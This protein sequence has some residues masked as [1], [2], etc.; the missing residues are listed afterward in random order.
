MKKQVLLGAAL[1]LFMYST[2]IAE[3]GRSDYDLDNDGLIEINDL[4]DLDEIKNDS[5]GHSLYGSNAGCPVDGCNGFEL[6]TDLD[7][8][9][10]DWYPSS[11]DLD[12]AIFEG[13]NFEIRDLVITAGTSG[14]LFSRIDYSTVRNL[15]FVGG[16]GRVGIISYDAQH[17]L[18]ENVHSSADVNGIYH[19]AGLVGSSWGSHFTNCSSTGNVIGNEEHVGGLIGYASN[20]TVTRC[21]STG[22]V[23]AKTHVYWIGGLIG[24]AYNS[25]II[26]SY[27]TGNVGNDSIIGSSSGGLVGSM[28]GSRIIDS[29]ATGNVFGYNSVG[30]LVGYSQDNT[31]QTSF[32]T[33]NVTGYNMYAG[34]LIG[35]IGRIT[36]IS[37]TFATGVVIGNQYV[38]G[39][40]GRA[41]S[42]TIRA[43]FSQ[44]NVTGSY[45][46]GGFIGVSGDGMNPIFSTYSTGFVTADSAFGGYIGHSWTDLSGVREDNNYWATDASGQ[47]ST[48]DD[49]LAEGFLLSELECPTEASNTSCTSSVLYEDWEYFLDEEL[50]PHWDFGT[51]EQLPGL[52]IGGYIYRDAN[53]VPELPST[54][55]VVAAGNPNALSSIQYDG[56]KGNHSFSFSAQWNNTA[57]HIT[58]WDQTGGSYA[59]MVVLAYGEDKSSDGL[60]LSQFNSLLYQYRCNRWATVNAYFG[61]DEDSSQNDLGDLTCNNTWQTVTVDISAMDRSDIA[62]ALWLYVSDTENPTINNDEMDIKIRQIHLIE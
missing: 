9:G 40:L 16:L 48:F 3:D 41:S 52:R 21:F 47:S 27:A 30:G 37:G 39:L 29:Y 2:V 13:N 4:D 54:F 44:G 11:R 5:S 56:D 1:S 60:D 18:I 14:G 33:G 19:S 59:S 24:R 34:G 22:K 46:V 51:S 38:G 6:T 31:I 8:D 58:D 36:H 53:G 23:E 12:S 28:A 20:T 55:K 17:S 61:S 62:T 32:A 43:S 57:L 42:G 25:D 7:F 15:H 45:A 35:D 50:E 49:V 10:V 26:E